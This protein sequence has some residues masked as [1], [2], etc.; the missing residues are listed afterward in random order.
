MVTSCLDGGTG[1]MKRSYRQLRIGEMAFLVASWMFAASA[2]E[3]SP[4]AVVE[5]VKGNPVGVEFMDYVAPGKV[6]RL[7]PQDSI[8]LGY[9]KSCWRESITGGTVTV[10]TEKSEVESGKV[11]RT[12]TEC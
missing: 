3:Q 11:E 2:S 7:G 1:R 12:K 5:E 8:V 9:M 10:G 6:I 4:A